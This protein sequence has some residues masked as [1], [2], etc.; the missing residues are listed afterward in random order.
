MTLRLKQRKFNWKSLAASIRTKLHSEC[1]KEKHQCVTT[2]EAAKEI[3]VS[4]STVSRVE[5][6]ETCSVAALTAFLGW[7]GDTFES[8]LK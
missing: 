4:A 7:L 6:E 5:R 1:T 2:R 8:H 3:G